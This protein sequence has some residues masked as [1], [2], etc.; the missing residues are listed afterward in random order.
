LRKR[1]EGRRLKIVIFLVLIF[2]TFFNSFSP[3]HS[4][5]H[6]FF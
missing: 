4:L 2:F 3:T 5:S 1:E 6:S